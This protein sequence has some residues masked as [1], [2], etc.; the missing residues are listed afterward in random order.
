MKTFLCTFLT[1]AIM[2]SLTCGQTE[3]ITNVLATIQSH[4]AEERIDPLNYPFITNGITGFQQLTDEI[5]KVDA[6]KVG[7]LIESA[8]NIQVQAVVVFAAQTLGPRDYL[9]VVE[10]IV[11]LGGDKKIPPP[12]VSAA[13]Y[14]QEN[15]PSLLVDNYQDEQVRRILTRARAIFE[16]M[17]RKQEGIDMVLNGEAKKDLDRR[18]SAGFPKSDTPP[19]AISLDAH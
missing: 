3:Q 10:N 4:I 9:N 18:R 16:G 19:P 14:P 13:I 5:A 6:S 17:P 15:L 8:P 1:F 7:Q 12:I 11:A 2:T